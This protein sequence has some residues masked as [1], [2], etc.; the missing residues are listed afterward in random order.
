MSSAAVSP[1]LL[2]TFR[3]THQL[4]AFNG[5]PGI[6]E[7]AT[8]G[9]L[10]PDV[11]V[12]FYDN[13]TSNSCYNM[14]M[15]NSNF[16]IMSPSYPSVF[17][18]GSYAPQAN[19]HVQGTAFIS[20]NATVFGTLGVGTS[21][22]AAT[23]AAAQI[24]GTLRADYITTPF[25]NTSNGYVSSGVVS[26]AVLNGTT[27][28]GSNVRA[29]NI[30]VGQGTISCGLLSNIT[31]NANA[32]TTSTIHVKQ[33]ASID[34]TL[35]SVSYQTE[36]GQLSLNSDGS[37]SSGN[38]NSTGSIAANQLT[39]NNNG[40]INAGGGQVTCGNITSS[41]IVIAAG[42]IQGTTLQTSNNG[43]L[44]IGTGTVICGKINCSGEVKTSILTM[45][46][47]VTETLTSASIALTSPVITGFPYSMVIPCMTENDTLTVSASAPVWSFY[48]TGAWVMTKVRASLSS[49]GYGSTTTIEIHTLDTNN[50]SSTI[51]ASPIVFAAGS[52]TSTEITSFNSLAATIT[53]N[54]PIQI[55]CTAVGAGAQGLKVT[56]FYTM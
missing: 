39:T 45:T 33:L 42:Y 32:I 55:F 2:G 27:I 46:N 4:D 23:T 25:L 50:A 10:Y 14:G 48:T 5:A 37:I 43:N 31:I 6:K 54:T 36:S 44:N 1:V 53:D 26:A 19:F 12:R 15:S 34:A 30:T 40:P 51:L 20:S 9:N 52:K 11:S 22:P 24:A 56:F 41:G 17:S 8:F 21:S 16:F 3:G 35:T 13:G 47:L 49:P 18:V 28:L 38:I 7:V 29:S